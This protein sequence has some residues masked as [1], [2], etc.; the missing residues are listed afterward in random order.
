MSLQQIQSLP[1]TK[2]QELYGALQ[3]IY[4]ELDQK[5]ALIPQPCTACGA[6]CH[7]TKSEHRLY[8]SSLEMAYL[9]EE[10][11]WPSDYDNEDRCPYQV[12]GKCS[13]RKERMIGCRTFFR[14]HEPQHRLIAED[15]YAEALA[16]IKSIYK[17]E[18]LP[19][20]Y[21]DLMSAPH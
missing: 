20:E 21:R 14:L 17:S 11:P 15:L 9:L 3:D 6:C 4:A 1:A 19:W 5:L 18:G 16:K 8:V 13:V 12:E 2:R 10:H 7:F